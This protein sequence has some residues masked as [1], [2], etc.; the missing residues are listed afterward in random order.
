[1]KIRTTAATVVAAA[2]AA[3]L[4]VA[5]LSACSSQ[6]DTASSNL[7]QQADSFQI[8]RQMVFYN[9]RT[10]AYIAEVTGLCSIGNSDPNGELTYTCK[11]GPDRYIKNFLGLSRDVTWFALQVAPAKTDPYHYEVIFRPEAILPNI[12]LQTSGGSK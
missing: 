12:D 11:V 3:A 10:G 9:A 1:M 5:G 2:L 4:A 8:E 7:S 6:A